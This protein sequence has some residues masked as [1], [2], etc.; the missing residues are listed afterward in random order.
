MV[1]IFSIFVLILISSPLWAVGSNLTLGPAAENAGEVLLSVVA[2]IEAVL[3]IAATVMF[4]SAIMKF[5]IHFQNPQQ[6]PMSTPITELILAIVLGSLP[7]VTELATR[8]AV[9]APPSV[10]RPHMNSDKASQAQ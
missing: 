7:I 9:K 8:T 2:L 6:I 10:L 3:Y 1:R 4:T 5:R